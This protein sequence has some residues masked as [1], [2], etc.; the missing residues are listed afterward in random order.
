MAK[1]QTL[2]TLAP[3]PPAQV[4]TCGECLLTYGF[5]LKGHDGRPICL[6]CSLDDRYLKMCSDPA[7]GQFQRRDTPLPEVFSFGISPRKQ[8]AQ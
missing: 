1:K 3:M 2:S 4:F 8:Q 7:C 6:R 5:C